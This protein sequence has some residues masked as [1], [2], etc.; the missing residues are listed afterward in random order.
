MSSENGYGTAVDVRF[1]A[2]GMGMVVRMRCMGC[3]QSRDRTGAKGVGIRQRCAVCL[4]AKAERK[5]KS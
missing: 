5:A 1:R 2:V 4:A 3:G